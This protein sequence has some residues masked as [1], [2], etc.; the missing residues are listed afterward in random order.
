MLTFRRFCCRTPYRGSILV[1]AVKKS[2]IHIDTES[3]F[4]E[5]AL[6]QAYKGLSSQNPLITSHIE[7]L[8]IIL[9]LTKIHR[10]TMTIRECFSA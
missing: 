1:A 5:K 7:E 4:K 9:T 3:T 6:I 8:E 2:L 10:I